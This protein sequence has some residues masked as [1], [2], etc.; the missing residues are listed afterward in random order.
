MAGLAAAPVLG[1]SDQSRQLIDG[2]DSEFYAA[3]PACEKVHS[4]NS[5]CS[6]G[7]P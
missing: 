7:V 1:G 6:R 2:C 4:P 3:G 5:V